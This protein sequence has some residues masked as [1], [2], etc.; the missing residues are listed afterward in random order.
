MRTKKRT[1]RKPRKKRDGSWDTTD[2]YRGG[3]NPFDIEWLKYFNPVEGR[4]QIMLLYTDKKT[5][6]ICKYRILR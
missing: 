1:K 6:K 2:L 5:K 4:D 3:K